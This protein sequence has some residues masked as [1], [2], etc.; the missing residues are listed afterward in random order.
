MGIYYVSGVP[1]GDELYHYRTKGSKNGVST[2]PGYKAVG[3]LAKNSGMKR[4]KHIYEDINN[5]FD[6]TTKITTYVGG[7]SVKKDKNGGLSRKSA[8]SSNPSTTY[9]HKKGTLSRGYENAKKGVSTVG[10]YLTGSKSYDRLVAANQKERASRGVSK[11]A[12]AL[13]SKMK[14]ARYSAAYS[15]AMANNYRINSKNRGLLDF[16]G[17]AA[18]KRRADSWEQEA[19]RDSSNYNRAVTDYMIQRK[20]DY[21]QWLVDDQNRRAAQKAFDNTVPGGALERAA[22]TAVKDIKQTAINAGVTVTKAA[23]DASNAV[24]KAA[25]DVGVWGSQQFEKGKRLLSGLFGKR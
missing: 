20:K 24:G 16:S 14:E 19:I 22:S 8:Y 11:E 4:D 1:F 7:S 9:I 5:L 23:I 17:R 2:T 18:D 6:S 21:D 3:E 15:K 12:R 25:K 13:E 10:E